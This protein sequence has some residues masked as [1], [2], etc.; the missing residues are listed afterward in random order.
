MP[1]YFNFSHTDHLNTPRL[2]ADATGTAVWRWDQQ[3][4]FGVNTP[5]ENPSSLGAFEFPLR[6]PGQYAD[7]ETGLA[8]NKVRDYWIEGGRHIQSDPIGLRGGLNTFSY[9]DSR[10]LSLSDPLGLDSTTYATLDGRSVFVDGPRNGNWCGA[11]WSGGVVTTTNNGK[12]GTAPPLDSLDRCCFNHD[13]CIGK[14]EM[15]PKGL[16]KSCSI[17]CD[18]VAVSCLKGLNEDCDK[19]PERPRPGTEADSQFFR[20]V[21][22]RVFEQEIKKWQ[23][24]QKP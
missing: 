16:Q 21:M 24:Q 12:D 23:R 15:L 5:D 7:K 22:I 19:W 18:R 3:E 17:S 4:P 10:P 1:S 6:F 8:Y 14:C 11:K 13:K 9:V 20:D 2:V